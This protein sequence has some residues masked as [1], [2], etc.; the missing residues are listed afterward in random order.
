VGF[1]AEPAT[2]L[3]TYLERDFRISSKYVL[4]T[5]SLAQKAAA[6]LEAIRLLKEIEGE[7]RL[8]NEDEKAILVGYTGWGALP[9]VFHPCVPAEWRSAA[10]ELESLLTNAEYQAARASTPNAHYTS[11][12]VIEAIWNALLHFGVIAPAKVLEPA[13]GIGH[14]F[15]FMTEQLARNTVRVG[16]E[17]DSISARIAQLLYPDSTIREAAFETASLPNSF[18]DVVV[19]NVPFGNYP[20]SA[21]AVRYLDTVLPALWSCRSLRRRVLLLGY[22][23]RPVTTI[24]GHLESRRRNSVGSDLVRS[25][26]LP[27]RENAEQIGTRTTWITPIVGT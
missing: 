3:A 4:G 8:A 17:L 18:F 24:P 14:F 19:G 9:Q 21:C 15:G 25:A 26:R 2:Q 6:N 27:V 12:A 23:P 20:V 7:S 16:I 10:S 5:G 13:L 22:R 11:S 1:V